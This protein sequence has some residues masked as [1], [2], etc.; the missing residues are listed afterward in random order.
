MWIYV[1]RTKSAQIYISKCRNPF[2]SLLHFEWHLAEMWLIVMQPMMLSACGPH[3]VLTDVSCRPLLG[4]GSKWKHCWQYFSRTKIRAMDE[5]IQM[6][7][8]N[9]NVVEKCWIGKRHNL[10][11]IFVIRMIKLLIRSVLH[12]SKMTD[13]LWGTSETNIS[14]KL[15]TYFKTL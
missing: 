5:T 3:A 15:W 2:D 10:P 11:F 6:K 13:L 9:S 4:R 8:I 12:I 1:K 14:I 7:C